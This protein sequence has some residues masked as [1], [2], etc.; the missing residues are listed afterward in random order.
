[1]QVNVPDPFNVDE[2]KRWFMKW[3]PEGVPYNTIFEEKTLSELLD[4]QVEKYH[5]RNFI[6]FLDTWITYK[7]FQGYVNSFAAALI[8]AL[9]NA[10]LNTYEKAVAFAAAASCLAHSIIGDFNFHSR[11]EVESLM[12]YGGSGRVVR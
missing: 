3:W 12:Q 1:M 9:S 7:Q 8:F 5:D 4:E 6:W 11:E 10:E 2:N